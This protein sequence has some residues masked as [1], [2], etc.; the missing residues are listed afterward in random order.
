MQR[1]LVLTSLLAILFAASAAGGTISIGGSGTFS[2]STPSSAFS[3]PNQPWNFSFLVNSNPVVSNVTLGSGFDA[4]FSNFSYL[5]NGS[6]LAITPTFVRFTSST[7]QGMFEIC[8]IPA[9]DPASGGGFSFVGPQMY[10]GSE[11]APTILTGGFTS[12]TFV[13]FFGRALFPQT[14]VTVQA[15]NVPEPMTL[16]LMGA[17]LLGLGF[18]R[19]YRKI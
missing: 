5:L 16:S 14:N 12:T 6:P 4:A 7:N 1:M 19:R 3:G 13:V 9:C 10:S 15:A 2:A 8:F 17:G 18:L 11:S